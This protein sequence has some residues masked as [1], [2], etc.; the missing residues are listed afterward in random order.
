MALFGLL[1]QDLPA[2]LA[3]PEPPAGLAPG[4]GSLAGVLVCVLASAQP[5]CLSACLFV[6][7]SW[8]FPQWSI[9]PRKTLKLCILMFLLFIPN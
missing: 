6:F 1:A 3:W 7:M 5:P 2:A 8:S 4:A 9:N